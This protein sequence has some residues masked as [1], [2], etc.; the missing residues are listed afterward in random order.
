MADHLH[1]RLD[2]FSGLLDVFPSL[3][4]AGWQLQHKGVIEDDCDGLAYVAAQGALQLADS[5]NDVY[6]VTLVLDPTRLPVAK[7]AHVI[8]IF[9]AGNRWYVISNGKIDPR[10]YPSFWAATTQNSYSH[11]KEIKFIEVRDAQ[12]ERA[13]PPKR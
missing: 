12:L 13:E 11:G 5:P 1:W 2:R 7:A 6:I 3:E 9:K 8:C 10:R 4:H